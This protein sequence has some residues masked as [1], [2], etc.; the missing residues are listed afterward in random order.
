MNGSQR[1]RNIPDH[2]YIRRI[3]RLRRLIRTNLHG[4]RSCTTASPYPI[5][6]QPPTEMYIIGVGVAIIIAIAIAAIAVVL[7]IK[8]RP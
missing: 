5:V 6:T 7:V 2:R 3:R 4:R 1:F 8:K